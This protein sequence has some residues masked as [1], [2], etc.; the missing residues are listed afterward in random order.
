MNPLLARLLA[1]TL[2][3]AFSRPLSA[4]ELTEGGRGGRVIKVT[5]LDS[6]GRGSLRDALWAKGPRIIVFEVG[7]V[8]DLGGRNL[9]LSEP[10][11]TI[12]GQTAPSPGITLIRGGLFIR[13]HDVIVQHLAV[14]PGEAGHAKKSG[15][16]ADGISVY[17]S[18][19][20]IVDHCSCT[21]S[22]D[23]NLSASGPRF[24]GKTPEEWR[25][26]TSHDV[27]FSNCIV[28]EALSNSTHG[29]GEHSKGTLMHDNTRSIVVRNNLYA[30][31]VDRNP[32][33]KGGVR[34]VVVNNWICNTRSKAVS[35]GLSAKEWKGHEPQTSELVIVGN[36][37]EYGPD[38]VKNAPLLRNYG[39]V[40]EVFLADNLAITAKG[41]A[42]PEVD[43]EPVRRSVQMPEWA[44]G[45]PV[46]PAKQVKASIA[47]NAGSRPWDRDPI[48]SRI[49]R[50]A[51]EGK[52]EIIDS[53][54][55]VGGYP[56]RA[57]TRA[58][59][60]ATAWNLATMERK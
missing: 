50:A 39:G 15:W 36:V 47:K 55:V 12:A 5:T 59:F 33:A 30:S 27:L 22:T 46:M 48:D 10:Y 23:E 24:E 9:S 18:H 11:V 16:E 44:R 26:N 28:A 32:Y 4:A 25:A 1:L 29:K 17:E 51:L 53:E 60:D 42:A 13:S 2:A 40:V 45:L 49:I 7:G 57:P 38:T 8:I 31:N 41:E 20:V 34:A 21:W 6:E 3:L 19:H 43:G 52:G 58:P 54:Q 56:K 14:R 35:H 37:F